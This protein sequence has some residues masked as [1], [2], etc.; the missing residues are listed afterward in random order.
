[1]KTRK[2][3]SSHHGFTPVELLIAM[4]LIVLIMSII[5]QA[6]SAGASSFR[7]LKAI[8]DL[9][10]RLGGDCLALAENITVTN[11]RASEF[12]QTGL[13]TGTANREE[14]IALREQYEAICAAAVDLE[15]R[16][17]EVQRQIENPR[18]QRVLQRSLNE[19]ERLKSSAA[20]MVRLLGLF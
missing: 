1:M 20:R 19:L 8:G 7:D 17:K 3:R 14:A 5:S 2:I 9:D 4:L 13:R 6:F 15:I 12:I 11:E 16:L 18:A 10:E